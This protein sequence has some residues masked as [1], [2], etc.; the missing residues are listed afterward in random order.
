MKKLI[1]KVMLIMSAMLLASCENVL[2]GS[3]NIVKKTFDVGSF[4]AIKVSGVFKV[5]LTQGASEQVV[6]EADDNLMRLVNVD[7]RG[8]TL[9]IGTSNYTFSNPTLRAFIT[10]RTLEQMTINGAATVKCENV[11]KLDNLS[12]N[13]NGASKIDL[14]VS[15]RHLAVEVD[16][17]AMLDVEGEADRI[18][19]EISGAGKLSARDCKT[20][21]ASLR[22]SGAGMA[23]VNV[24]DELKVKITGAG[25]V[26]YY[27][28]PRL[29]TDVSVAAS[30][31][32]MD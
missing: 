15:C 12:I 4:S 24:E 8:G 10:I 1:T 16:G 23:T 22:I 17:A 26:K 28:D 3:G 20:Q 30:I 5:V 7:V 21:T 29:Y 11:L 19:V 27:G 31:R 13:S 2:V 32:K 9:E 25:S 18:D 6:I 14:E